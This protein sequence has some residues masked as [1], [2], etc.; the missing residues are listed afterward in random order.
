MNKNTQS[1]YIPALA[2]FC[3]KLEPY[4]LPFL[5]FSIGFIFFLHG[6][7]KF[8]GFLAAGNLDEFAGYVASKGFVSGLFWGWLVV[9]T[10]LVGG[11]MLAFGLF[12]RFAALFL[13]GQMIIIVIWFKG[14]EAFFGHKGGFEYE[15]VYAIIALLFLIRGG[16]N[17]ALDNKLEKTF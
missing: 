1:Y 3:G 2:G 7:E 8:Q 13:T 15:L 5:R 9:L 16:G 17:L 4:A 12:T 11:L 14:H 6:L 10:E